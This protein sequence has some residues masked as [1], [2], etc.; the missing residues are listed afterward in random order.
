MIYA[1]I[2][3]IEEWPFMIQI[4]GKLRESHFSEWAQTLV[5]KLRF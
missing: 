1:D 2:G 3:H 5:D 4:G